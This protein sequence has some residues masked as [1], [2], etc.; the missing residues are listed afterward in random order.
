MLFSKTISKKLLKHF[1]FYSHFPFLNVD[2]IDDHFVLRAFV[3]LFLYL[4]LVSLYIYTRDNKPKGVLDRQFVNTSQLWFVFWIYNKIL[5]KKDYCLL[6]KHFSLLSKI[7]I[8]AFHSSAHFQG[9]S[10]QDFNVPTRY[11]IPPAVP[12]SSLQTAELQ[13]DVSNESFISV[14]TRTFQEHQDIMSKRPLTGLQQHLRNVKSLSV[15]EAP[16]AGFFI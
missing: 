2:S 13:V 14:P 7:F 15:P 4:S 10:I 1:D 8:N 12:S 9:D 11:I 5:P 6:S 16:F 3:L